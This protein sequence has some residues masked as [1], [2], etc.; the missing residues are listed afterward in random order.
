MPKG[1][2]RRKKVW[3]TRVVECEECGWRAT[4]HVEIG[5]EQIH[6][7]R[8]SKRRIT[9]RE[10]LRCTAEAALKVCPCIKCRAAQTKTP[11]SSSYPSSGDGKSELKRHDVSCVS[12]GETPETP[13][14]K[15]DSEIPKPG[16]ENAAQ[17]IG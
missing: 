4:A 2:T 5:V 10:C 7:S 15:G 11:L 3:H 14:S 6:H 8:M 16:D 13:I 17:D 9:Q 1:K 12:S